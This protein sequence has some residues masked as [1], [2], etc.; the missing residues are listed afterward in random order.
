MLV[1]LIHFWSIPLNFSLLTTDRHMDSAMENGVELTRAGFCQFLEDDITAR[2]SLYYAVTGG[3]FCTP[4]YLPNQNI[5]GYDEKLSLYAY[6]S[7]NFGVSSDTR[8]DLP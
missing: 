6:M 5:I 7:L 3:L 1:N 8:A 4:W 2:L